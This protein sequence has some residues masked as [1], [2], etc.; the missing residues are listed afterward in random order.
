VNIDI[1][2]NLLSPETVEESPIKSIMKPKL[3]IDM[4]IVETN[5]SKDNILSAPV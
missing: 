4:N 2:K 3:E 5:L 1:E